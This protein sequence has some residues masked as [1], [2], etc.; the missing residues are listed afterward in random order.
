MDYKSLKNFKILLMD[1]LIAVSPAKTNIF[2]VYE[3]E[4]H[5]TQVLEK[6]KECD[7]LLVRHHSLTPC[8]MF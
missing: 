4:P 5:N 1:V 3:K 6:E 2:V 7:Q 8:S